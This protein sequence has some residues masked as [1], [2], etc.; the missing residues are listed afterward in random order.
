MFVLRRYF[1]LFKLVLER[2][3][4]LCLSGIFGIYS[5]ILRQLFCCSG[6]MITHKY[7]NR[8][9]VEDKAA[10][11]ILINSFNI[12]IFTLLFAIEKRKEVASLFILHETY[13]SHIDYHFNCMV[14]FRVE[15]K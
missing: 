8:S 1:F 5:G 14:E 10:Y 15:G 9:S 4:K 6:L 2:E 3:R 12:S 11:V 7:S 13:M